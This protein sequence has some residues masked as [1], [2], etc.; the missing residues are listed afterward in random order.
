MW[1]ISTQSLRGDVL[2]FLLMQM[3]IGSPNRSQNVGLSTAWTAYANMLADVVPVPSMWS[4]EERILLLGTS[5]EVSF[6]QCLL[7]VV[8]SWA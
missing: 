7:N 3:T 6:W 5:L 8:I 1:L 4:E 2:L